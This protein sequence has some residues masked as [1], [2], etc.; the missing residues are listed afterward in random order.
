[1][2]L[3]VLPTPAIAFVAARAGV[4]AAIVSAS[5][6][7]WTR[8]RREGHRRRR[9]QAARRRRSRDRSRARVE[10]VD[11]GRRADDDASAGRRRPIDAGAR[12]LRRAPAAALDGPH[13]RR[14][15]TSCSTARTARRSSVGPRALRAA[16]ADVDV[17][18]RR[19]PTAATSTTL[20]FDASRSR[21]S[22]RSSSAAPTLGLA[23]DGDADRVLAV[24]EHGEL[25][26]GD[27]IMMMTALDLHE[28]GALRND[29]IVVTVMSN[30]GLRRAL[31]RA[32]ASTS[33]RR[34]SATATSSPRCRRAISCS[35]ASSR[36]TSCSPTTRRPATACSPDCSSRD[37]RPALGAP[38][39]GA[40]GAD[41]A[42]A[43]R[44][45]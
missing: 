9:P 31:A 32:R 14:A 3:G 7:P 2:P 45:S 36:A 40:R 30:L 26:D 17:H 37:L 20:R 43:R 35:A 41:D 34:R 42:R 22:A 23:L 4:P 18:P 12:R 8:Q 15:R 38:A 10:L 13:A 29:A 25:V 33:S 5:H 21:C 44:C 6:N 28:R 39:V 24:D 19:S 1:M 11:L 16:G 27:Q